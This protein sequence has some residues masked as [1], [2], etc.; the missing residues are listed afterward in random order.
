VP[1]LHGLQ[2]RVAR[3]Y[4]STR[5]HGVTHLTTLIS[6]LIDIKICSMVYANDVFQPNYRRHFLFSLIL[7]KCIALLN[8]HGFTAV[9]ILYSVDRAS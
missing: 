4:V 9:V 8:Y 3:R 5:L 1:I 2:N 7:T 6:V